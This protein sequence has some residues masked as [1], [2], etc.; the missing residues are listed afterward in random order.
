MERRTHILANERLC[1]K[2]LKIEDGYC[3]VELETTD[4]MR[5]DDKGLVHGGFTFSVADLSAMLAVNHPFVVLARAEVSFLKP[6][7]VGDKLISK[8]KVVGFEEGEGGK[9]KE[10]KD[11]E[12]KD[13]KGKKK[14]VVHVEVERERMNRG[15][16][17]DRE[18]RMDR[19]KGMDKG[20]RMD[21][22]GKNQQ[23]QREKV[24]EGKFICIVREKH[25]L[26]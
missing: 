8:A 3:E 4:E 21:R 20:E 1:G 15:E 26:D 13:K 18:E 16:G 12:G 5:V 19:G 7:V 11:K 24:F 10:G 25:V 14:Y 17:I 23:N 22:E 2:V 6:V 9:D